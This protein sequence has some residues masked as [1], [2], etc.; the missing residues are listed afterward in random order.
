[1]ISNKSSCRRLGVGMNGGG[2]SVSRNNPSRYPFKGTAVFAS[3]EMQQYLPNEINKRWQLQI[4]SRAVLGS[5]KIHV[6]A[7]TSTKQMIKLEH[8]PIFHPSSQHGQS[9][10]QPHPMRYNISL[11]WNIPLQYAFKARGWNV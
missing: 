8:K 4:R 7:A 10:Y 6:W 3:F 1:M 5:P 11:R 2:L 9:K